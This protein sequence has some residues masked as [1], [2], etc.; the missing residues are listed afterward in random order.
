MFQAWG[1]LGGDAGKGKRRRRGR[2][3]S[4]RMNCDVGNVYGKQMDD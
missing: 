4:D 3:Y 1:R 2:Y